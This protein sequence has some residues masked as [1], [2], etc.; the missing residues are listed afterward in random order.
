MYIIHQGSGKI[1]FCK[2]WTLN[3]KSPVVQ[4]SH[5]STN[6][7]PKWKPLLPLPQWQPHREKSPTM[8]SCKVLSGIRRA[9]RLWQPQCSCH[10]VLSTHYRLHKHWIFF[11][12]SKYKKM[13]QRIKS[14]QCLSGLARFS[15]WIGGW[16]G[17]FWMFLFLARR[18]P[19][20]SNH[21]KT[22]RQKCSQEVN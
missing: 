3:T 11:S 15:S 19:P 1:P 6:S 8:N 12:L 7:T 18:A 5:T 10:S 22:L 21:L 16:E 13:C 20:G 4:H 14:R 17:A 9:H 2:S